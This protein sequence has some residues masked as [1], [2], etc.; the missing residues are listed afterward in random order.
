MKPED[1]G[2]SM[3][4][5]ARWLRRTALAQSASHALDEKTCTWLIRYEFKGRLLEELWA[6]GHMNVIPM[7]RNENMSLLGVPVRFTVDDPGGTPELQLVMEPLQMR[8]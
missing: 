7:A 2:M 4:D 1:F 5:Q 6:A 3:L 8:R